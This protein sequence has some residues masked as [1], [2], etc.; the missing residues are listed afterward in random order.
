CPATPLSSQ[1][2]ASPSMMQERERRRANVSTMSGKRR[3]RSLPGRLEPHLR[4]SLTGND[5]EAVVLDLVQPLAA[6]GQISFALFVSA[7]RN[8]TPSRALWVRNSSL[9]QRFTAG[10]LPRYLPSCSGQTLGL[11]RSLPLSPRPP[12]LPSLGSAAKGGHRRPH[13]SKQPWAGP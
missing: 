11:R 5:A 8:R 6:G 1:A 7:I 4:A 12:A 2:T 9:Q 10:H 13:P 3:V